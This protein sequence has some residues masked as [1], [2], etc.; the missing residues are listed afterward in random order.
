MPSNLDTSKG[1]PRQEPQ[2]PRN[3]VPMFPKGSD[4]ARAP[5]TDGGEKGNVAPSMVNPPKD[6]GGAPRR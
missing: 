3:Y 6:K 2:P 4:A 5:V 1:S